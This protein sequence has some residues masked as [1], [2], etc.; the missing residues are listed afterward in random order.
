MWWFPSLIVAYITSNA[1][2]TLKFNGLTLK[3]H[4]CLYTSLAICYGPLI[5]NMLL[6]VFGSKSKT[7]MA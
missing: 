6:A 3:M 4:I 2:T 1:L 5:L 7:W